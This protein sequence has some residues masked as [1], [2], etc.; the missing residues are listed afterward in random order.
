MKKQL[1]VKA[2]K[3]T[4]DKIREE[5]CMFY[6]NELTFLISRSMKKTVVKVI[7]KLTNKLKI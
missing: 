1:I 2:T 6:L 4:T 7:P 3:A 5:S